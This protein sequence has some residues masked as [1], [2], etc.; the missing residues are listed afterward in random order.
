M[1]TEERIQ[2]LEEA[3]AEKDVEVEALRKLGQ[4]IGSTFNTER[5]L[6][7]VAEIAVQVTGTDTCFIYI[8]NETGQEL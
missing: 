6:E 1:N 7:V 3:L 2:R 5:L 4:A 8:L